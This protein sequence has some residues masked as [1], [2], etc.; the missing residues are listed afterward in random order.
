MNPPY[1]GFSATDLLAFCDVY[2]YII[3]YE[4]F[5]AGTK[6]DHAVQLAVLQFVPQRHPG[7]DPPGQ[8]TG[9]ERH[10]DIRALVFNAQGIPFVLI[11]YAFFIGRAEASARVLLELDDS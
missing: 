5:D 7:Y 9:N 4:D 8:Y 3:L 6:L 1:D 10:E 2:I 11:A